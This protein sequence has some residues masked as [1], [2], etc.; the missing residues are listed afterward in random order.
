MAKNPDSPAPA[1]ISPPKEPEYH[2]SPPCPHAPYAGAHLQDSPAQ[3]E[4]YAHDEPSTPNSDGPRLDGEDMEDTFANLN[5][6]DFGGMGTGRS[7]VS[8]PPPRSLIQLN[9]E[10]EDDDE[11]MP[12]PVEKWVAILGCSSF[13]L[14]WNST[15]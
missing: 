7:R 10:D 3:T 15:S 12:E 8:M 4:E 13:D 1:T 6:H 2:A 11:D 14:F 9:E 5:I